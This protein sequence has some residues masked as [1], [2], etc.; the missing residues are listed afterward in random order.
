MFRLFIEK[1][2]ESKGGRKRKTKKK[3]K[4]RKCKIVIYMEYIN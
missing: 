4:K 2:L 3:K 1:D